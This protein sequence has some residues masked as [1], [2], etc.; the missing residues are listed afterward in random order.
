MIIDD[1]YVYPCTILADRYTG[2]YSGGE[3]T[4]W[5]MDADEIPVAVASGNTECD[6]F[7][8]NYDGLVGTGSDPIKAMMDLR[9]KVI[10]SG[11]QVYDAAKERWVRRR[12]K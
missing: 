10:K 12:G 8:R 11:M 4:A 7:W 6:A 1:N 9:D 3:W 5:P 2:A